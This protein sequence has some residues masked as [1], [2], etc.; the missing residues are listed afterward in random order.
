MSRFPLRKL[1]RLVQSGLEKAALACAANGLMHVAAHATEEPS[2]LSDPWSNAAA[3][4]ADTDDGW[5]NQPRAVLLDD[6]WSAQANRREESPEPCSLP[7][8]SASSDERD[9]LDDWSTADEAGSHDR[10]G[11]GGWGDCPEAADVKAGSEWS[12][13]ATRAT[14]ISPLTRRVVATFDFA[15]AP[16]A[17]ASTTAPR[18]DAGLHRVVDQRMQTVRVHAY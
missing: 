5:G 2:G 7:Q 9:E 6:A 1:V 11:C 15:T 17:V 14:G 3:E 13:M 4:P 10:A 12:R 18:F 16:I 8:P